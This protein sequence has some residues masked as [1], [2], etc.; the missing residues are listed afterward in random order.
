MK[1]IALFNNKGGV[2]KTTLVYHLAFAF[3][4]MGRRVLVADFDP[5]SNLTALCLD[6]ERLETLWSVEE[7]KRAT[8]AGVV[9]PIKELG[10]Q[11]EVEVEAVSRRIGLVVGDLALAGFDAKLAEAWPRCLEGVAPPF[12]AMS[13][14]H[15]AVQL[16]GE[17]WGR[18]RGAHRRRPQP[19]R[20]QPSRAARRPVDRHAAQRRP[21]LHPGPA[22]PRSHAVELARGLAAACP[23]RPGPG[24][25]DAPD[26]GDDAG[27]IC[28]LS[29]RRACHPTRLVRT[30]GGSG[31]GRVRRGRRRTRDGDPEVRR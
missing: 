27:R 16:A 7:S 22:R 19:R 18:R 20:A 4:R 6:E 30:L 29:A 24:A 11:R 10:G 13:A 21:L 3:E 23:A 1:T 5:Q 14:L 17:K 8:V 2:G 12:R 28:G 9:F 26:R 25:G 31:A 15:V